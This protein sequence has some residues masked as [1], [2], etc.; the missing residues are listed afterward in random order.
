VYEIRQRFARV[1]KDE[2]GYTLQ[3]V[4]TVGAIA[5]AI[6]LVLLE[7]CRVDAAT[8]Q[9]VGD[10]RLAH[11]SATNQITDW[12]VVLA[13]D[14]AEAEEG[15]D[16]YLVRLAEPYGPGGAGPSADRRLSRAH[17]R[18]AATGDPDEREPR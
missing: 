3:E 4:L 9:F 18:A 8:K 17:L 14:G 1:R 16:Y 13:H 2:R 12:R 5:A 15:P 11:G 6:F 7:R 10:L